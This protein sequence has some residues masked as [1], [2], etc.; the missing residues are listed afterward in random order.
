M[1]KTRNNTQIKFLTQGGT[2]KKKK[3]GGW[4]T[5]LNCRTLSDSQRMRR[6]DRD[7]STI[8]CTEY[9][10]ELVLEWAIDDLAV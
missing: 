7:R 1:I 5:L 2:K 10:I 4:V 6:R 9:N 3:N 8:E